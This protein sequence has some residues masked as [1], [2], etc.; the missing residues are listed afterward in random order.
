VIGCDLHNEPHGPATWGDGSMTT[1]WRLAAE[2]AGNAIL[3]VNPDL[4]I[5]VEGVEVA[6][7]KSYWW[8]GNL[9]NA[10]AY[11]VRLKVAN[12][13]VYSPHDYP[14]TVW[15]QS[16]F[17]DPSYP[18]NLAP[19]WDETWGYLAKNNIAPVL[20]GEF[21]TNNVDP[22]DKTWFVTIA[23][24]LKTNNLSFTF[25]SLNPNSGDT[26]GLLNT[27]WQTVN[28]GKQDVLAPLQAPMLPTT[29]P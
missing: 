7:G 22:S 26:G 4:L 6:G 8:G 2:R 21:G 11:P 10:G 14:K 18:A 13:L 15:N 27:D 12:R 28:Q 29:T 16:W 5:I 1:D 20:L 19:L 23:N 9:R 3:S 25:W 24:Y 17:S